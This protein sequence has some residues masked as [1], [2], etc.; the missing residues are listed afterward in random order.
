MESDRSNR[1]YRSDRSHRNEDETPPPPYVANLIVK[2]EA[3]RREIAN[4]QNERDR[5]KGRRERDRASECS[6]NSKRNPRRDKHDRRRRDGDIDRHKNR[7]R[8]ERRYRE[9]EYRNTRHKRDSK[10]KEVKLVVPHFHG[11]DYVEDY[12]EWKM[13]VKQLFICHN[14]E[15][16]KKGNYKDEVICDVVPMEASHLLLGRP[17]QFDKNVTHSGSSNKISFIHN[18]KKITLIPLTSKQVMEDQLKMKI[19]RDQEKEAIGLFKD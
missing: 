19:K 2:M 4:L 8:D 12:I 18:S 11:R 16:E 7:V 10:L 9:E 17:W 6:N 3:M 13:K 15:E 14:I 1:S 5:E